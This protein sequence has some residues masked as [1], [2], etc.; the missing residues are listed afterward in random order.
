MPSSSGGGSSSRLPPASGWSSSMR[1]T[2]MRRVLLL[3]LVLFGLLS[4][5]AQPVDVETV[6]LIWWLVAGAAIIG[7]VILLFSALAYQRSAPFWL[8][9]PLWL[10]LG[11]PGAP[12]AGPTPP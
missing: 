3:P 8:P 2:D 4:M 5:A 9:H 7:G 6:A 1:G 11:L 12:I 10:A